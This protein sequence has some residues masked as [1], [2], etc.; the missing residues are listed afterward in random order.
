MAGRTAHLCWRCRATP[1]GS[2]PWRC[3]PLATCW[4]AADG[5]GDG[6]GLVY[7]CEASTGI[8]LRTL[9]RRYERMDLRAAHCVDGAERRRTIEVARSPIRSFRSVSLMG[10]KARQTG[11]VRSGDRQHAATDPLSD[12]GAEVRWPSVDESGR[13]TSAGRPAQG[14]RK[15]RPRNLRSVRPPAFQNSAMSGGKPNCQARQP[16]PIEGTR[17]YGAGLTAGSAV[18]GSRCWKLSGPSAR[19]GVAG[20]SPMRLM[21]RQLRAVQVGISPS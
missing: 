17:S 2:G 21:P 7:G 5:D 3:P 4:P 6:D 8:S 10:T 9:E 1:A 13:Y 20:E 18:A 16:R 12:F 11:V 19:I 15:W 14:C